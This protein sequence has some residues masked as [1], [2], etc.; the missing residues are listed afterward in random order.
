MPISIAVV[1]LLPRAAA[2]MQAAPAQAGS[3]VGRVD[4]IP[5][6]LHPGMDGG[7]LTEGGRAARRHAAARKFVGSETWLM[8]RCRE[9]QKVNRPNWT[10][11]Y[12]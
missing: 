3:A 1:Q 12:W 9:H 8:Q 4:H 7:T 11:E 2:N 10:K 5:V 6:P